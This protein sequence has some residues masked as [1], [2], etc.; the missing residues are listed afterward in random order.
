[1]KSEPIVFGI[2]HL[3]QSK[4]RTEPWDGVRNYQ[5]RNFICE[6]RKGDNAFF[7]HSNCKT[8][9]IVGTMEIISNP[10]PDNSALDPKSR[11]FDLKSTPENPRWYQIDVQFKEKFEKT[12][13]LHDLKINPKLKNI[14]LIRKGNRLSITPIEKEEWESILNMK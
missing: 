5:A 6:M 2:Q 14:L 3:I 12:I 10:Y 1:M 11:Y 8:P 9:G 7:Y 4:N 13:S